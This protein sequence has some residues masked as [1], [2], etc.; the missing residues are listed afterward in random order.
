MRAK[1]RTSGRGR[2]RNQ[3]RAQRG[4]GDGPDRRVLSGSERG[5]EEGES[6]RAAVWAGKVELGRLGRKKKKGGRGKEWACWA[7]TVGEEK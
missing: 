7:E 2:T 5:R 3:V 6:G 1:A 4:K